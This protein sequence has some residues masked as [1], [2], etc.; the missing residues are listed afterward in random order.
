M[1]FLKMKK[2]DDDDD[3]KKE[4]LNVWIYCICKAWQIETTGIDEKTLEQ[5]F[6]DIPI[7]HANVYILVLILFFKKFSFQD[8]NKSV[9]SLS[10]K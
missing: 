4:L 2:N 7:I 8:L 5:I 10:F 9:I 1:I 6:S 3:E